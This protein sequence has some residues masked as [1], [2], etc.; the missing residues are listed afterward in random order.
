MI[1]AYCH[2]LKLVVIALAADY[3]D[4]NINISIVDTGQK[5]VIRSSLVSRLLVRGISISGFGDSFD[6]AFQ[7]IEE[8]VWFD[9]GDSRGFERIS[10]RDKREIIHSTVCHSTEPANLG[11]IPQQSFKI[12]MQKSD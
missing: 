2:D 12:S 1:F 7:Q 6:A 9:S 8:E 5:S 10:F 4:K 3:E 11:V